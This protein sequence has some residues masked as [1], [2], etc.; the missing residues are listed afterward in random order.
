LQIVAI[1]LITRIS[2]GIMGNEERMKLATLLDYWI[3]HND[4]HGQEFREWAEK[5]KETGEEE[6]CGEL[7]RAV[8]EMEKAGDYLRKAREIMG[9]GGSR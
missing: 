1:I 2:G 9:K 5:M 7:L 6:I 8:N 4:E 3:D